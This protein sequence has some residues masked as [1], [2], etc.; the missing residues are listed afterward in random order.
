M[1]YHSDPPYYISAYALAKKRGFAGNLDDWLNSLVGP[2]GPEGK[3]GTTAYEYAVAGGFEGTEEEFARKMA[4]EVS[5][6]A[7]AENMNRHML[8]ISNPH[9][10]NAVQV[11]ALPLGGGAMQGPIVM[12]G[13]KVTGL[14]DPTAD[15][16]AIPKGYVMPISEGGTDATDAATARTKLGI[17]PENI[18]AVPNS[19]AQ[20]ARIIAG[21]NNETQY[22]FAVTTAGNLRIDRSTD[23]GETWEAFYYLPKTSN[24]GS[25]QNPVIAS[26]GRTGYVTIR[27]G[28]SPADGAGIWLYGNES[29]NGGRFRLQV[30]DE[31]TSTY[32]QFD[33]STDGSLMWNKGYI[34]PPMASGVEYL[35]TERYAGVPVYC[36]HVTYTQTTVIGSA[37]G[38]SEVAIPHGISGFAKLVR[39]DAVNGHVRNIPYL[40]TDGGLTVVRYLDAT[41]IYLS[42]LNMTWAANSAAWHFFVYY[43]KE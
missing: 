21:K 35:T 33:G 6:I 15:G 4:A 43:T 42:M 38:N 13:H 30:Y 17:T 39:C 32:R 26:S 10:T 2:Q 7:D 29:S 23:S 3:A 31:A 37:S 34:N 20:E 16:D 9:G 14:S 5:V 25:A 1:S 36:K 8:N 22:R 11:G 19:N 27:N 41:N 24:A 18:G 12:G 28:G 40:S